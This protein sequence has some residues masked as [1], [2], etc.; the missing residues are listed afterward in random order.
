MKIGILGAGGIAGVLASTMAGLEEAETYA[1]ASRT[2]EKAERF[3]EKYGFSKAYGSYEE[4]AEDPCVELVYIATP[5]SRHYEDMKLCVTHGKPVLCEKAFTMNSLEARKIIELAAEKKVFVAEAIWP[6]Y[7]PSRKLIQDVLSSGVIGKVGAVTGNLSY[8]ISE[9]ERIKNPALAGGALLDIGVYGLNFVLMHFGNQIKRLE[10]SVQMMETGVDGMESITI[11]FEDGRM[12]VLN[13]SAYVRSDRK[14]IF[15]GDRGYVV[16]ENINN[17]QSISVYDTD[18]RLV[19]TVEI[20]E[21]IS[22]YEYEL[23]EC[24]RAIQERKLEAP[25]MPL[26]DTLFVMEVMDR[27]RKQWGMVYPKERQGSLA[28]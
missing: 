8:P 2:L 19:K 15:H 16:V 1:I 17:P 18:D 20:P 13:H 23:K 7:M 22:G 9:V 26:K 5:H 4:L 21:Q 6:R 25:S 24:I 3:A 28:G 11:F 12:A 10:S 27:L 14:G